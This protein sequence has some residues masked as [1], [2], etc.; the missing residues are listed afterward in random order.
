MQFETFLVTTTSYNSALSAGY[1][2]D[3]ADNIRNLS[4]KSWKLFAVF[5]ADLDKKKRLIE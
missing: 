2:V 5:A 1:L 3:D 4:G